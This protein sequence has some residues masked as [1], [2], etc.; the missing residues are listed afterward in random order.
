MYTNEMKSNQQLVQGKRGIRVN[1][2]AAAESAAASTRKKQRTT[3]DGNSTM[4]KT[5]HSPLKGMLVAVT[6][7]SSDDTTDTL[8]TAIDQQHTQEMHY[9]DLVKLCQAAGAIVTSQ[10]HQRVQCVIATA[11]A[12]EH[13]T[14]RV[15]K[16]WKKSIPVVSV[17]WL[18]E[19]QLQQRRLPMEAYVLERREEVAKSKGSPGDER[20][21]RNLQE[22][23]NENETNE[24][25]TTKEVYVRTVDLGCCCACH[26]ET[27][28][29]TE[30]PWCA[31]C[32]VNKALR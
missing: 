21:E 10:V 14:Q 4:P 22:A 16:A 25:E 31:D 5:C 12:V 13:A 17:D 19:C 18:Q 32:S 15:R 9:K 6:S 11:S 28:T 2:S 23:A 26:D 7:A 29:A 20:S 8:I 24:N 27:D 3:D 30:C 1:V